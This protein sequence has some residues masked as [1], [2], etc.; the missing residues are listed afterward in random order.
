MFHA[1]KKQ[2]VGGAHSLIPRNA[3][4][5][6]FFYNGVTLSLILLAGQEEADGAFL[7]MQQKQPLL[8]CVCETA[9]NK[10]FD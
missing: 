9:G 8:R 10:V 3:N 1:D 5:N 7:N 6:H 4:V 2:D